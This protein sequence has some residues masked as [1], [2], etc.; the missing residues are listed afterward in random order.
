M[1][2]DSVC[3]VYEH[4]HSVIPGD[5]L[6]PGGLELTQRGLDMCSFPAGAIILDAGCGAGATVSHL[7][8]RGF[9][10]FGIDR[11]AMLLALGRAREPHLPLVRSSADHLPV[12]T[13]SADG[14]LCECALSVTEAPDA[15]LAE[16]HRVL[17]AGGRLVLSD[18]YARDPSGIPVLRTLP[19]ECCLRGALDVSRLAETLDCS[20]FEIRLWED[21]SDLFARFAA[22][23]VWST[24]SVHDLWAHV[25]SGA[26]DS[27]DIAAAVADA[28]PGYFLLIATKGGP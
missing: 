7:L 15:A 25:G 23:L 10:P 28:R 8:E 19:I 27:T 16:F 2:R 5:T 14:V 22:E 20:R 26:A 12:R 11:S 9:R 21:H 3:K 24:G 4:L 17:K 18:V 6:R 1:T 13:A